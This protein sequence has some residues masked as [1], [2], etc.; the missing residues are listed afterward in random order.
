MTQS[1]PNELFDMRRRGLTLIA[2]AVCSAALVWGGWHW[3]AGRHHIDTD[4]AYVVGNV[5]QITP[6]VSGTVLSIQAC[7]LYTSPSPRD[8]S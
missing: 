3:F 6:Q 5:L 2:F 7:L 8:C 4:N 1:T